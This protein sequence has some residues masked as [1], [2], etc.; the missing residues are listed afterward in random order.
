MLASVAVWLVAVGVGIARA[1]GMIRSP[2]LGLD[3][4]PLYGA[5]KA[6]LSH[7]SIY[8]VANFVYPPLAAIVGTPVALLSYRVAI[9]LGAYA[10]VVSIVLVV[11]AASRLSTKGQWWPVLAGLLSTALLSSDLAVRSLWLE[12]LS[13]LLAPL[14]L[15]VIV[16][17]A[18]LRWS[19]AV[20]VLMVTLVIKPL[21]LPFLVLPLLGRQWRVLA[22]ASVA[23]LCATLAA[24]PLTGG[25][26][27]LPRVARQLFHGSNLVGSASVN[28]LSVRGFGEYHELNAALTGGIRVVIV[29][30]AVVAV[31]RTASRASALDLFDYAA[32]ATLLLLA[33]LLAGSLSENHYL[34][35][36]IPGVIIVG[37]TRRAWSIQLPLTVGALLL[38]F[39]SYT[40]GF[41]GSLVA[42][43]ARLVA[44]ELILFVG[45][46]AATLR[47]NATVRNG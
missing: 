30:V 44:A 23:A 7:H 16:C 37:F 8:T 20:G 2:S 21:L 31:I 42:I 45:L 29:A 28:N 22:L 4:A 17:A 24:L 15:L 10:E 41:G 26:S 14:A 46:A 19:L 40:F 32:I 33:L 13:I 39:S 25:A 35:S 1:Q 12:N 36:V 34:F 3:F 9:V 5:G 18:R 27:D 47:P 6:V 43:Q 11:A 38:L